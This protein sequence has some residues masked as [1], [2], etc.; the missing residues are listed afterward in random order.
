MSDHLTTYSPQRDE[1]GFL[2]AEAARVSH[3]GHLVPC[4]CGTGLVDPVHRE[5]NDEHVHSVPHIEWVVPVN[6]RLT[7]ES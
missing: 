5:R 1:A 6:A 4:G 7:G 3:D 2:D